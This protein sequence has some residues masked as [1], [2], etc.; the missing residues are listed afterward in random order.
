[1]QLNS[2]E[3][4]ASISFGRDL[5]L[6][7]LITFCKIL[8][9]MLKPILNQNPK[10]HSSSCKKS[11]IQ[12]NPINSLINPN[13]PQSIFPN[14]SIIPNVLPSLRSLSKAIQSDLP[15]QPGHKT[16][17]RPNKHPKPDAPKKGLPVLSL[18]V[19]VPH[20]DLLP[21][22]PPAFLP[23]PI[24]EL[25]LPAS[26][27]LPSDH[28]R[29]GHNQIQPEPFQ[30]RRSSKQHDLRARP[31]FQFPIHVLRGRQIRVKSLQLAQTDHQQNPSPQREQRRQTGPIHGLQPRLHRWVL[32]NSRVPSD[33]VHALG[34]LR[35]SPGHCLLFPLFPQLLLLA[36]QPDGLVP[37]VPGPQI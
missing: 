5:F 14:K 32:L 4:H 18:Q 13:N 1:M 9:R 8:I 12:S 6:N 17:Q 26:K 30:S 21:L 19:L 15:L 16:I 24:P 2:I 34:D 36:A 28:K 22:H 3:L 25:H 37:A 31:V 27:P 10:L 23:F 7:Y 33:L 20:P 11:P 29:V 35:N